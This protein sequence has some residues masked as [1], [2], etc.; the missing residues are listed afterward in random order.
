MLITFFHEIISEFSRNF[1]PITECPIDL[2]PFKKKSTSSFKNLGSRY[3]RCF[4][5]NEKNIENAG[6][7]RVEDC[8]KKNWMIITFWSN[9]NTGEKVTSLY[10]ELKLLTLVQKKNLASE[11]IFPN[12]KKIGFLALGQGGILKI[13]TQCF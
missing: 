12:V 2:V 10:R 3:L 7:N 13:L 1:S 8:C 6:V 9:F 11:I 5:D 4:L